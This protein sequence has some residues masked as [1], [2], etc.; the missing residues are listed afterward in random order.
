M[1]RSCLSHFPSLHSR[2][3]SIIL[4]REI[5]D[6]ETNVP[7]Y[8]QRVCCLAGA[9]GQGQCCYPHRQVDHLVCQRATCVY[10]H[11]KTTRM[12]G[13]LLQAATHIPAKAI[14]GA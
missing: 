6:G 12:R 7:M 3:P 8:R 9:R 5:G 2:A 11:E 10:C 1:R 4:A 13:G 14:G